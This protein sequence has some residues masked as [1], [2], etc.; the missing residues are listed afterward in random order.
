MEKDKKFWV[1]CSED[2]YKEIK[3]RAKQEKLSMGDYI[4]C[5]TLNL[6]PVRIDEVREYSNK[7]K[8]K[9]NKVREYKKRM[10]STKTIL[11][12]ASEVENTVE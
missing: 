11:K 7:V 9:D 4:L 3:T 8:G 12:P 1:R 5:K 2:Y 10:L 6:L